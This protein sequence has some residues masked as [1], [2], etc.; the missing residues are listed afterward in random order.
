MGHTFDQ[1]KADMNEDTKLAIQNFE[2]PRNKKAIQAFFGLVNW[3]RRFIKNLA[4]MIKPLEHLLKKNIKFEWMDE[5]QRAFGEIKRAFSEAP[6]LFIIR[7]GLKFGIFV[8]A[9]KYGLGARLYQC[10]DTEPEKRYTMAYARNLKGAELN[11][12]VT[13]IE[14]LALVWAFRKWHTTLLGRHVNMDHRALKFIT[15]CADD[16]A[17]IA[18]WMAFLN[19]FELEICHVP[20]VENQIRE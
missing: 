5:I 3:D 11:Y 7:P 9:S 4:K 14:C 13:E 2:K 15:A 6:C 18:R 1:I 8:D 20:G 12:T 10:N 17:G 19:E 16:S